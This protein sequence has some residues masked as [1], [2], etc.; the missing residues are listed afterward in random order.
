MFNR[1]ISFEVPVS[2]IKR[3]H[4]AH[5]HA[6]R[7][8]FMRDRDRILYSKPF[9]RLSGKTQVFLV[10]S[11]DHYRT[12]LTHTLEVAQIARTISARL[13][14]NGDLTEAMALGHDLGHTPFGHVGERTLNL[15]MNGCEDFSEGIPVDQRGFKH[16]LQSVRVA[17]QFDEQNQSLNLSNFTLFGLFNHS[18][19]S[20]TKTLE[21]NSLKPCDYYVKPN[22]YFHNR[23]NKCSNDGVMS[24]SFYDDIKE[25]MYIRNT[26]NLAWS[27]E[28]RVVEISDE[29]AQRHHDLEDGLES[30]LLNQ[31]EVIELL[32]GL[33]GSLFTDTDNTNFI[34]MADNVGTI[35]FLSCLSRFIVNLLVTNLTENSIQNLLKFTDEF[36]LNRES[37]EELYRELDIT[38]ANLLISFSDDFSKSQKQLEEYLRNRILNSYEVQR[39][40]GKAR[41]IV[42]RLFKAYLTNPQQLPDKAIILLYYQ[43]DRTTFN[44]LD[45]VKT[46]VRT[47]QIGKLRNM[48]QEN[49]ARYSFDQKFKWDLLRVICDYI[50]GMTDNF[51]IKEYHNLYG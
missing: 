45:F 20:W 23:P 15:V 30:K 8:D 11:D 32:K 46:D 38:I 50:A 31:T 21:D 43:F 5:E 35:K 49:K 9:R 19:P 17:C 44:E 13:K 16:N 24:V 25:L 42:R 36:K 26:E 3:L 29:I 39:M 51:A 47:K 7:T 2:Y 28:A 10:A 12:R 33:F 48:L 18:K 6:Y 1:L 37:F 34:E 14:L 27:F 41:F 40:D 4:P 22:C